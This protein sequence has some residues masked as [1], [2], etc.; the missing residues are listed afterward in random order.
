MMSERVQLNHVQTRVR[1]AP[2]VGVRDAAL[3]LAQRAIVR[4]EFALKSTPETRVTHAVVVQ[5]TTTAAPASRAALFRRH[6][7]LLAQLAG[8]DSD[9]FEAVRA[10]EALDQKTRSIVVELLAL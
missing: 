4:G 9:A 2:I 8:A 6:A 10:F 1:S 3:Q 7:A 5:P